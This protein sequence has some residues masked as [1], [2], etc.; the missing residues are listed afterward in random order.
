[1]GGVHAGVSMDALNS[2]WLVLT[3]LAAFL[4]AYRFYGAFL[5]TKVAV[6][7]DRNITPAHRLRDDV[8]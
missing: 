2:L 5:A 1:M 7:N 3:A 8:D 4:V 6:L